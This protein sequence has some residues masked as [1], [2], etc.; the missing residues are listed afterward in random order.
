MVKVSLDQKHNTLPIEIFTSVWRNRQLVS[1]LAKREVIGRYRGS[2]MGLGWSFLNPILMLG[3]YTIFFTVVF[4]ARWGRSSDQSHADYAIVLFVGLIVHGLFAECLNR[5]PGLI[6]QNVNYV[7]KVVFPLEVL[8]WV[9]IISALLHAGISL[10][11][12]LFAQILLNQSVSWTLIFLPLIIIP[13]VLVI[14]GLVWFLAAFGVYVRDIAHVT[15]MLTSVLLFMSPVFYPISSLPVRLQPWIMLNP[16][17]FV[18]EQSRNVLIYAQQPN[19]RNLGIYSTIG[20]GVAWVG[21][22]WFQK[23]RK[24]FADVL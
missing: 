2:I 6:V 23:A 21:F 22:W 8:P 7:K 20:L 12:L 11:V 5:A 18:I 9:T 4:K 24:G 17:T 1:Q 3:V 14:L 15:G 10:I 16:L 19:W 13:F